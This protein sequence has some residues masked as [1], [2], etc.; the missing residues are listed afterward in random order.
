MSDKFQGF[1][2]NTNNGFDHLACAIAANAVADTTRTVHPLDAGATIVVL[3]KKGERYMVVSGVATGK[4]LE[5]TPQDIWPEWAV[6]KTV[7]HEVV[8]KTKPVFVPHELANR[9]TNNIKAEH[10]EE[11]AYFAFANG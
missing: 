6:T 11:L 10:A 7:V 3:A 8:F 4:I 9:A 5:C 2:F 1:R